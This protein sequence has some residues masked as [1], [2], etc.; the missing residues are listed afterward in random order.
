ML[1]FCEACESRIEKPMVPPNT[2]QYSTTCDV[3][4]HAIHIH[5]EQLARLRALAATRAQREQGK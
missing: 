4:G 5:R 3:C 2:A 1:I